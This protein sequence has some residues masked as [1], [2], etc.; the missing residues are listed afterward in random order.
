MTFGASRKSSI[1]L[2]VMKSGKMRWEGH[3]ARMGA[4]EVRTGF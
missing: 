3:V 1:Y 2:R 4:V